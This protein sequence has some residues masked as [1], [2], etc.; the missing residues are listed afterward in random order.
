M[1]KQYLKRPRILNN[2]MYFDVFEE[3]GVKFLSISTTQPFDGLQNYSIEV[4]DTIYWSHEHKL[5]NL[6]YKYYND[7]SYWWVIALVNKKPTDSHYKIGDEVYIPRNPVGLADLLESGRS[8][9][10]GY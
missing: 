5:F 2:D 4:L 10:S 6:A 3:R 7:Y 8:N 1:P 9:V